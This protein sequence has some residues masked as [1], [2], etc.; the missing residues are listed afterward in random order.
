[1]SRFLLFAV[2]GFGLA[3][4]GDKP[5]NTAS[6]PTGQVGVL[7][8]SSAVGRRPFVIPKPRFGKRPEILTSTV[9]FSTMDRDWRRPVDGEDP[10]VVAAFKAKGWD[11]FTGRRV[12]DGKDFVFLIVWASPLTAGDAALIAKSRTLQGFV[13]RHDKVSPL[14]DDLKTILAA[15]K[16]E[17]VVI[18]ARKLTNAGVEA[19]A[20][21]PNLSEVS[22]SWAEHVSPAALA[23]LA[24]LP[25]IKALQ[26]AG[27]EVDDALFAAL[28]GCTSLESLRLEYVNGL[29]DR[30]CEQF[31]RH[32][33][34]KVLHIKPG[35]DDPKSLTSAGLTAITKGRIP[36]DFEFPTRLFD[37]ANLKPLVEAGWFYG[38]PQPGRK[39]TK[40]SSLED[41]YSID[42][43]GSS[44]TDKGFEPLLRCVHLS[45]LL[46]NDTRIGDGTLTKF[47]KFNNL[48]E[49]AINS[50]PV[51]AAGLETLAKLPLTSLEARNISLTEDGLK[52]IGRMTELQKLDLVKADFQPALISHLT[53]LKNLE[54]LYLDATSCDDAAVAK[55]AALPKLETITVS[56]TRVGDAGFAALLKLPKLKSIFVRDTPV[57]EK[58]FQAEKLAHPKVYIY[59][60]DPH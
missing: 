25:K 35:I 26:L 21:S 49:V 39:A 11:F 22:L 57:T 33:A 38:P 18:D 19:I 5:N 55:L 17:S 14:D 47:A 12:S 44:V 51:T 48:R 50:C 54:K 8:P 31:A 16:L 42:L 15:P 10:A 43:T 24:K 3:G 46:V 13:A 37:D 9:P 36:A 40:P 45:K 20:S 53:G 29:T 30:A 59:Y 7:A 28:A 60:N 1:M 52:A 23:R 2:L 6:T 41:V 32:P 34:L 4:C 58:C 27:V 56:E